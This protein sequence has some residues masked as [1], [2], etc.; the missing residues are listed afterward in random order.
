MPLGVWYVEGMRIEADVVGDVLKR[1]RRIEG[2][3]G[4]IARTANQTTSTEPAPTGQP[5]HPNSA[6]QPATGSQE[7]IFSTLLKT[8][9]E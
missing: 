7:P 4:G 6:Q 9:P 2:Q 5:N 3:L 1:L 8:L